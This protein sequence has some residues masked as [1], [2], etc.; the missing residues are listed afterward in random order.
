MTQYHHSASHLARCNYCFVRSATYYT[1]HLF[2]FHPSA[3][4]KHVHLAISSF[5]CVF[6]R[7]HH[8]IS[9]HTFY[10][11]HQHIWYHFVFL[12]NHQLSGPYMILLRYSINQCV[13]YLSVGHHENR[14]FLIRQIEMLQ[15]LGFFNIF[16]IIMQVMKK[17]LTC[18]IH[19]IVR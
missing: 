17:T 15:D 12:S 8:V 10:Y 6:L 11:K 19:S 13:A 4:P 5:L 16:M 7:P 3:S 18:I 2:G 1:Y 14:Y 9:Y